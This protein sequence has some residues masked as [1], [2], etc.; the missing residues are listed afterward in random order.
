MKI[1]YAGTPEF[2]AVA[3]RALLKT[4]HEIIAVYTQPD[5]PAGRGR[6][7]T[8]SAVKQVALEHNI[9]VYQPASLKDESAQQE[10][11]NLNADIMVVAAY[12]LL[13]PKA[14]LDIP[15]RGCLN[16]H[17]SLLPRW[18]GAA[19]IQRAIEAGDAETGITIM[20]MDVGLDTGD[21][22]L[23]K[24][25]EITD[26]DTTATLHDK[27]AELGGAAIV[28]ALDLLEK[29]ALPAEKQDDAQAVY[30]HKLNKAEAVVNWNESAAIIQRKIRA[31][32]PWPVAQTVYD[33]KVL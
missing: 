33:E 15:I 2:A 18:R 5:R 6:K 29:N 22:L 8:P 28:E 3:L 1:I 23:K 10:L 32:N 26:A 11:A 20:Q 21:M 30:A 25:C 31:F 14:V 27:L 4:S 19:P 7:L 24:S 17:G 13:L 16:I 12:G 9:P